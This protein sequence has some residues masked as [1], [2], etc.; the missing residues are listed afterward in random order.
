MLL[1]FLAEKINFQVANSYSR[2][3]I[4]NKGEDRGRNFNEQKKKRQKKNNN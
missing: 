1:L 3:L 4:Q 2:F